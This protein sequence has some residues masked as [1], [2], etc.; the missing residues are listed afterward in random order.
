MWQSLQCPLPR[1][2]RAWPVSTLFDG[3]A[4]VGFRFFAD[5]AR[6][7]PDEVVPV[8]FI[9]GKLFIIPSAI[10]RQFD[11]DIFG[12]RSVAESVLCD[13]LPDQWNPK[14][15]GGVHG[16]GCAAIENAFA[17]KVKLETVKG[18]PIKG[19]GN[20]VGGCHRSVVRFHG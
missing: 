9:V 10:F 3:F 19:I 7:N 15:N 13:L 12:R 18:G 20:D 11:A 6:G 14:L 17:W 8:G 1:D 5:I 16:T 4:V 2:R